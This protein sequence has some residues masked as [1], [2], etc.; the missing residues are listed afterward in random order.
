LR[1]VGD[2]DDRDVEFAA[3]VHAFQGESV[4]D[5]GDLGSLLLLGRVLPSAGVDVGSG[6]VLRLVDDGAAGVAGSQ[7]ER[8]DGGDDS[9]G[10]SGTGVHG[11]PKDMAH[12][13]I[14][15]PGVRSPASTRET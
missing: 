11:P 4:T 8:P 15:L 2:L 9:G 12:V 14:R 3:L 6:T 7:R 13:H 1:G 10:N 5:L